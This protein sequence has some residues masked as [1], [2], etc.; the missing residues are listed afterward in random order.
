MKVRIRDFIETTEG[1]YFAVNTY[2]HPKDRFFAFLR[3]VPYEYIDFEIP[4]NNIRKIDGRKYVKIADTS[5]AYKFLEKKFPKYLFYDEVNSVLMHSIPK[6]DIKRILKPKERLNEIVNE[7]QDLNELDKKCRKL[8]IILE[9]YGVSL[10]NMG[11]SGS[12]LLKLNNENSD[13][14]FVIYGKENH[15]KARESLKQAFEDKKLTP[16]SE[17]FWKIAYQKR[18]KDGTLTYEEFVFYEKRKYNRGLVDGTMFDLLFTREWNEINEEYGDKKYNNL[19]FIEIEGKILNDD[20]AFDNPA[21]YRVECYTNPDI[22]E[23]VSFTHT[24]AGQCFKGEE[25]IA[26]GKLEEVIEGNNRYLRLVVGTTREAFNE[27][28]KLKI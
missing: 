18:I 27:F 28:I 17:D 10:K 16:L 11:V 26:R 25:F 19:G 7:D 23:V 22:K 13:I 24:Y 1:L 15:K 8:A 21:T 2:S 3:Y 14:D 5:L 12:L 9:D 6:E 4:I 20:Y